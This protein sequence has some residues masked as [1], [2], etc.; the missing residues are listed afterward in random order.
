MSNYRTLDPAEIV[1]TVRRLSKRIH[2]RFPESGLGKVC[3]ELVSI[4]EK[5]AIT[6]ESIGR[7]NFWLRAGVV[8]FAVV[9]IFVAGAILSGLQI[10][11]TFVSISELLQAVEAAINDV[12]FSGLAIIFLLGWENRLKRKRA[13]KAM[14]ELRSMAH[15]LDLHQL[16]KD[17]ERIMN[18]GE[19]TP[20]S[21]ERTMTHFEL[22]RYLDYCSEMLSIISKIAAIY[23]QKFDDH[24]TLSSVNEL[25]DLTS[26]LSRKI[27][28]KIMILDRMSSVPSS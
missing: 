12:V 27:W 25:E 13:L 15:I 18:T 22:I 1:D 2:E 17:P 3:D 16:T 8:I 20:S 5:A 11:F 26:G 21:P 28:Q 23:V 19:N 9:L 4:A 7:T 24:V 14:H 10:R 6:S